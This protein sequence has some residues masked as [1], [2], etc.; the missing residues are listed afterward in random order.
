MLLHKP[1][2]CAYSRTDMLGLALDA[3]GDDDFAVAIGLHFY[4]DKDGMFEVDCKKPARKSN[5]MASWVNINLMASVA[6]HVQE[7]I[8]PFVPNDRVMLLTQATG[9]EPFTKPI[10]ATTPFIKK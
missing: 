3:A 7:F 10:L 6:R 9:L 8:L 5:Q 2:D 1:D 4:V